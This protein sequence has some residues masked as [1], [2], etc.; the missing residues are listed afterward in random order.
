M[1]IINYRENRVLISPF[2]WMLLIVLLIFFSIP[3]LSLGQAG[4]TEKQEVIKLGCSIALTGSLTVEGN[5]CKD[6]YDLWMDTVNEQGGLEVNGKRY[7]IEITYYDDMSSPQTSALL[8]E[9]FIS[10]ENIKLILGP[11]SSGCVFA[12]SNITERYGALLLSAGGNADA[13]F[14]RGYKNVFSISP[15][16]SSLMNPTID[17][18]RMLS[19]KAE[20]IA[21]LS[22]DDVFSLSLAEGARD[23]ALSVG[24]DVVYFAKYPVGFEDLSTYLSQIKRLKPDVF[25]AA[26]HVVKSLMVVKQAK[27]LLFRPMAW[28][29]QVGPEDLN[30]RE[31]LGKDA[32]GIFYYCFY[33]DSEKIFWKDP[34]FGDLANWKRLFEEKYGYSPK[35][36]NI[37]ASA[38]GVVYG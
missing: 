33:T 5:L 37:R 24:M 27:E 10:D 29:V 20:T 2:F 21:I 22:K 12:V 17:M 36:H 38:V 18:W 6:G 35:H 7:K 30:F 15:T 9:K 23:Y 34:V 1:N 3:L 25:V 14:N 19:P 11:M 13:I 28:D 26:G 16:P 4:K 31:E 8:A 32:D